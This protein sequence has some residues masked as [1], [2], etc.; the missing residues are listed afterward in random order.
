MAMKIYDFSLAC[1]YEITGVDTAICVRTGILQGLG[2]DVKLIFPTPPSRRELMLY[3]DKGLKYSQML[4]VHSYF[5]DIYDYM[6]SADLQDTLKWLKDVLH[7]SEVQYSEES[8]TL[9]REGKVL[10]FLQL[11]EDKLGFYAIQYYKDA[12]IIRTDLYS[13]IM[14]A[15]IF[16]EMKKTDR[17]CI[18]VAKERYFYNR[19]G[20]VA[21]T[22]MLQG[23]REINILPDGSS[24][25]RD[26]LFGKFIQKLVLTKK[27]MVILDRPISFFPA[28][29]LLECYDKTNILAVF[30]SE[31][32]FIKGLSFQGEYLGMEYWYWCKYS[33]YIHTMIVSTDE[34]KN[35][36][37]ETLEEY[38]FTIPEIKTIP[39]VC[40]DKIRIPENERKRKSIVCI[41][42][43]NRRKKIDWTIYTVIKAHNV[44]NEITLDIYGTGN[45]EYI[46]Y[47]KKLI[48]E[49]NASNYITLKGHMDVTDIYKQYEVYL[50]TSLWE[51][52][53]ITL[54]EAVGSGLAMVGLDVRYGNRLFIED[55][56]NGY[57]VPYDPNHFEQECPSEIDSLAKYIVEIVSDKEKCRRFSEKSYEIARKYLPEQISRKWKELMFRLDTDFERI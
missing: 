20:S 17:G 11:T 5:S 10:A 12:R 35:V 18:T 19:D 39:V 33:K 44:D 55:G 29:F 49:H 30:H 52:F 32:F 24:Y 26:Q 40:L 54:L 42:R 3:T 23:E 51:T 28:K 31:H 25:N 34:Q 56:K 38:G 43:L 45:K 1:G 27:D 50:T 6:P 21:L 47:L 36:L 8:I 14:Y 37:K 22:Q 4:G 7:Y 16:Y 46:Q 2:Y 48:N 13:D 9:R 41:S 53:G 15:S 57:L